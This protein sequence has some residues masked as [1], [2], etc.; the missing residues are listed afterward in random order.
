MF[1][2]NCCFVTFAEGVHYIRCIYVEK[3]RTAAAF[4]RYSS[5]KSSI[6]TICNYLWL[7]NLLLSSLSMQSHGIFAV[8]TNNLMVNIFPSKN[9]LAIHVLN[10]KTERKRQRFCARSL[11]ASCVD[12]K[13]SMNLKLLSLT[14]RNQAT[15]PLSMARCFFS[16]C[17]WHADEFLFLILTHKTNIWLMKHKPQSW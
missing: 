10:W 15:W 5:V 6:Q 7:E 11:F 12:G 9:K 16:P 13:Y 8:F 17:S 1:C 14:E 3:W 4:S 2:Y